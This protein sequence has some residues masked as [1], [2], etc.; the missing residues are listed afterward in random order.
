M[1][2]TVICRDYIGYILGLYLCSSLLNLYM[3]ISEIIMVQVLILLLQYGSPKL[4][5]EPDRR[6][7]PT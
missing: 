6:P 2:T 3:E 5:W 1:E 7:S 4:F